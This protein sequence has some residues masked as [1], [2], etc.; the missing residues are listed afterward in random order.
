[1]ISIEFEVGDKTNTYT[2][3]CDGIPLC[4]TTN[5]DDGMKLMIAVARM[6]RSHAECLR[7][8]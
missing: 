1:M 4:Y 2:V 7:A 6:E 5:D 3:L 8:L